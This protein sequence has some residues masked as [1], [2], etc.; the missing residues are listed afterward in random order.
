MKVVDAEDPLDLSEK[1]SQE[2][3]VS[4]GHP[5]EAHYDLR[6]ELLVRQRD[7]GWRPSPFKQFLNLSRI[8]RTKLVHE[9]DARVELRESGQCVSQYPACR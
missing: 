5:Y 8:E 7:S 3:E 1:S 6:D 4:S 9:P 2:S